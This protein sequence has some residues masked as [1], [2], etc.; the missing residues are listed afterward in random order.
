M[1]E[2]ALNADI[3]QKTIAEL[4]KL[5][6]EHPDYWKKQYCGDFDGT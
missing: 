5:R 2:K 4:K 1:C 6:Y 3:V